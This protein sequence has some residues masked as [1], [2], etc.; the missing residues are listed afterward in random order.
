[1]LEYMIGIMRDGGRPR[2]YLR[3]KSDEAIQVSDP[4]VA[5]TKEQQDKR[6]VYECII[7]DAIR[8]VQEGGFFYEWYELESVLIETDHTPPVASAVE[9]MAP[10]VAVASLAFVTLAEGGQI[11]D[12]TAAEHAAQFDRWEPGVSYKAGAIRSYEGLLYRCVQDHTSQTDWSP[13]AAASLWTKI[14]D[15][16]EEWPAW[17][18]PIGTHDAYGEG[19]K[20]S[21]NGGKWVSSVA[22]N[23][24]EP[25]VYG[26]TEYTG[27]DEEAAPAALSEE[28]E[29]VDLEA[30]T[31]PQLKTYAQER[32][33]NLAGKT[34]KADII[35]A[36]R[37]AL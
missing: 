1:M 19:D 6:T 26:W 16:S 22:S 2:R 13:S 24:W 33:I 36:I 31:I 28:P 7:G 9:E 29:A 18:Q 25:G 5:F 15:P 21:H 30:M 35:E 10:G 11:D 34:L 8:K 17:S 27:E 4:V 3:I 12:V 32:G 23:V 20:V 14:A 37:A